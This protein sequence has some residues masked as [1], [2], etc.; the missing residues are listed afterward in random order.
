MKRMKLFGLLMAMI[1]GI[2]FTACEEDEASISILIDGTIPEEVAVGTT[3]TV[4]YSV[5]IENNK[6]ESVEILQNNLAYGDIVLDFASDLTY[7]GQFSFT[8][9]VSEIGTQY[10]GI[11][12]TDNKGN[13]ELRN[14]SF[15]VVSG[16]GE[17]DTYTAVLLGNQGSNEGSFYATST[18]KV[19]KYAETA[20]NA[21]TIDLVY[22][23]NGES[24]VIAAPSDAAVIA[25]YSQVADWS[26]RNDTEL[27]I[28]L[29][30]SAEFSAISDDAVI[31]AQTN[32][33]LSIVSGL[34][35]GDVVAFTTEANKKGLFIVEAI[36]NNT[37]TIEVKVQ[38]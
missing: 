27:K 5:T 34:A 22:L 19:Y 11:K 15:E 33:E 25:Q 32:V 17:I 28:S 35:V 3:L 36:A 26:V 8:P 9:Q 4:N 30:S 23:L 37:M 1:V 24:H 2:G 12:V 18:N 38:Q 21:A 16:A 7:N 6:L 10:F 20:A 29:L 31:T 14:F 13:T